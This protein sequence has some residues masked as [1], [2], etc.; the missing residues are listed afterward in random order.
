MQIFYPATDIELTV[1]IVCKHAIP[2]ASSACLMVLASFGFL[3]VYKSRAPSYLNS[4]LLG[5]VTLS[6][7][8]P[9]TH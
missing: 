4:R 2:M 7:I 9:R 1:C 6:Y 5:Y 3:R 8:E